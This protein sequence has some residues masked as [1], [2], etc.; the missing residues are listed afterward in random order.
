[1]KPAATSREE[2]LNASRKLVSSK[3]WNDLSIRS[4][5]AECEV[6]I[7]CLYNYFPSKNELLSATVTTIWREIF[8]LPPGMTEQ[9]DLKAVL[10]Q[11]YA[12]MAEGSKKYPG[13]AALHSALIAG[14][15]RKESAELMKRAWAQ[16]IRTIKKLVETDPVV[17]QERLQGAFGAEQAAQV[18]FSILLSSVI[19]EDYDSSLILQ[20]TDQLLF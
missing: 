18:L 16:I 7:G 5:A 3:G 15:E 20:T 8:H 2:I 13:F 12:Q 17:K 19:R 9:S 14:E 10:R 1:M 11:W 6:S 4:L